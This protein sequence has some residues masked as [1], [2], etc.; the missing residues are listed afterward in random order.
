MTSNKYVITPSAAVHQIRD[1]YGGECMCRSSC[2][3]A[4]YLDNT[5]MPHRGAYTYTF[6]A[7]HSLFN[8]K[9]LLF[10]STEG[11]RKNKLVDI[12]FSVYTICH[13]KIISPFFL[14]STVTLVD[15]SGLD[16]IK[17]FFI[18]ARNPD[19]GDV[20]GTWEIDSAL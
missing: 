7:K 1:R 17:G 2:D 19:T 18:Q 10:F 6:L 11:Y 15:N 9:C 3:Q 8:H 5:C 13:F 20:V 14:F 12:C 4:T 16:V